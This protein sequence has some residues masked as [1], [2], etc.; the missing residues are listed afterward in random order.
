MGACIRIQ[1][2]FV[3]FLL[4]NYKYFFSNTEKKDT[5]RNDEKSFA[6]ARRNG[7]HK[8]SSLT[9]IN[10]YYIFKGSENP[11]IISRVYDIEWVC[12]YDMRSLI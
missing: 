8:M 2:S 9:H 4:I 3:L 5:T 1:E 12:H 6:V 10:N 11:L 7:K